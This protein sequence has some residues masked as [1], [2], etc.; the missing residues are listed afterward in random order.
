MPYT[1]IVGDALTT[2]RTMPQGVFHTCVTSPPYWGLRD[3]GIAGQLGLEQTP[4]EYVDHMIEVF[5]EVRRTLRED[6]T[7]WLNL[8]DTYTQNGRN[9]SWLNAS[10][11]VGNT[12][13]SI[14]RSI[15]KISPS[16]KAKDL[17]G[18]PWRLAFALQADGWYLRSDIIW[19]KPNAMP[20]SITDRP[21]KSHEYIFLL[22]KSSRYFYDAEAI[23]EP[24]ISKRPSGNGF[25]RACRRSYWNAD[26]TPR[27]NDAQ[28]SDVGGKRNCRTVWTITTKPFRDAH[29][30]TFPPE[31]PEIC[32]KAGTSEYGACSLC[33]APYKRIIEKPHVGDTGKVRPTYEAGGNLNRTC[34]PGQHLPVKRKF[35]GWRATCNHKNAS[36]VPCVVLDPFAGAGT[37]GLVAKRYGRHFVGIELNPKY[38]EMARKRILAG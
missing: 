6:G 17:V 37:T 10:S 16:L 18:I 11:K 30:A 13:W 9:M 1:I 7:L 34:H 33:R 22:T 19:H 24:A 4:E 28:W 32:I 14:Q 21:T 31:I 26:G 25:K 36:V 3:Y 12:K 15:D 35:L 20:E 38:A 23:K 27:G 2:L 8:G 29:F 5:R